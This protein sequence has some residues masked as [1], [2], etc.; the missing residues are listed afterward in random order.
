MS[1]IYSVQRYKKVFNYKTNVKKHRM[2]ALLNAFTLFLLLYYLFQNCHF[3]ISWFILYIPYP[4]YQSLQGGFY[5]QCPCGPVCLSEADRPGIGR[6]N[7]PCTPPV[8]GRHGYCSE[9][10]STGRTS[11][12][13]LRSSVLF[14][15]TLP[16]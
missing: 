13:R 11:K 10:R 1:I 9:E 8:G 12:P 7:L 14:I 15:D 4:I 3:C 2:K 16:S 6:K 5:H